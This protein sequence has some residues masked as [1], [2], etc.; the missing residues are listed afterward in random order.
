MSTVSI[1]LRHHPTGGILGFPKGLGAC[2]Y[3][4]SQLSRKALPFEDWWENQK[5][6]MAEDHSKV[7]V[8]DGKMPVGGILLVA[9]LDAQ[10]GE[11]LVA[12]HQ[13]LHKDYRGIPGL[14]RK[15]LRLAEKA[16]R[17]RGLKWLIW[18]HRDESTGRIF[19]TYK[20]V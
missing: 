18:T 9:G 6:V 11:A 14:W 20:E 17:D 7:I 13:F 16:C 12:Y 15:V 4:D 2:G 19:Y 1:Q 3:R 8:R 5:A 10:V